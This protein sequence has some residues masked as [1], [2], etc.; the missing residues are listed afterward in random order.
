M[1]YVFD[2][3]QESMLNRCGPFVDL[4]EVRKRLIAQC[5]KLYIGSD[6]LRE[7]EAFEAGERPVMPGSYTFSGALTTIF[8]DLYEV[9]YED[10]KHVYSALTMLRRYFFHRNYWEEI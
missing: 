9:A 6:E 7:L 5:K 1:A 4:H 3:E 8:N 10:D 2:K